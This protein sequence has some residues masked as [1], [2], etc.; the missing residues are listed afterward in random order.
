M[1]GI[2]SLWRVRQADSTSYGLLY[3]ISVA[4]TALKSIVYGEN[5]QRGVRSAFK[6]PGGP[7]VPPIAQRRVLAPRI[8]K[9]PTH[10]GVLGPLKGGGAG[11]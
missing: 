10:H 9:F 5:A 7:P 11:I 3:I 1:N 2:P 8:A 6:R 4:G